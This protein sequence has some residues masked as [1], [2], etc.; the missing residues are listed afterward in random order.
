MILGTQTNDVSATTLSSVSFLSPLPLSPG[1]KA[2]PRR[3]Y[4]SATTR[5]SEYR[6]ASPLERNSTSST[7]MSSTSRSP[8]FVACIHS[9]LFHI[10][11]PPRTPRT[12]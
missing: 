5:D 3:I 6:S 4:V 2:R 10:R 8:Y 1:H 11:K 12:S 7:K 9:P